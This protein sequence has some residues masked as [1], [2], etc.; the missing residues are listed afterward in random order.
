MNQEDPDQLVTL[1]CATSEFTAHILVAILA[2]AGI[3]AH[4]FAS[5]GT[6]IGVTGLTQNPR[7]GVPVQVRRHDLEEARAVLQENRRDSVDIDWDMVDVGHTQATDSPPST[8]S[9]LP[10]MAW[11]V[12]AGL[13]L[14]GFLA[15][16]VFL[17][18]G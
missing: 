3:D 12:A 11:C 7:W 1:T 4:A 9:L 16:I 17:V 8:Q 18:F 6:V 14:I 2:D 15:A 10:A 13:M 5:T